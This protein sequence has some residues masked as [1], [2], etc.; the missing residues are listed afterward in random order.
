MNI[1][2]LAKYFFFETFR[3]TAF[4]AFLFFIAFYA[5]LNVA[6]ALPA[7]L[8]DHRGFIFTSVFLFGVVG[9]SGIVPEM[10]QKGKIELFL[11]RPFSRALLIGGLFIGAAT[12]ILLCSN[13]FTLAL[14]LTQGLKVGD[15]NPLF[16]THGSILGIAF[17]PLL[18]YIILL[19]LIS[20][21]TGFVIIVV[22]A[23]LVFLS[24]KV[25]G[26][27]LLL[28]PNQTFLLRLLDMLYFVL[29]QP[30]TGIYLNLAR[31]FSGK[32]LSILPFITSIGS[33]MVALYYSIRFF[34]RMDF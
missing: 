21:N 33:G 9:T 14:W 32:D 28:N 7:S 11:S 23:Y 31:F 30:L 17:I 2:P 18:C 25:E 13:L 10:L 6:G 26:R 34:R 22:T 24:P 4:K 20:R 3:L 27:D 19:G 29:P 12:V 16:L 8:N 1:Y 15:W 5:L